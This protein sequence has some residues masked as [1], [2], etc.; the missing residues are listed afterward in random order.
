[1][2]LFPPKSRKDIINMSYSKSNSV[3]G[4][5]FFDNIKD[6]DARFYKIINIHLQTKLAGGFSSK[7]MISRIISLLRIL[8]SYSG[9]E[10][11]L[12]FKTKV[13]KMFQPFLKTYVLR[14]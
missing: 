11:N 10:Y 1:M 7:E 14:F 3:R 12:F 9:N 2:K 8:E 13:L 4:F 5:F 6:I